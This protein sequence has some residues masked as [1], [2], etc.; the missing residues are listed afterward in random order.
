MEFDP[1]TLAPTYRL[2]LDVPGRSN[3]FEIAAR[4]GLDD[5]LVARARA[6]QPTGGADIDALIQDL[7]VLRQQAE[8][9]RNR[10][11]R[12]QRIASDLLNKRQAALDE[13][14]STKSRQ[15]EEAQQALNRYRR[16]VETRLRRIASR[17][18]R[19]DVKD[20]ATV[21]KLQ[22]QLA[23]V[24]AAEPPR[25]ARTARVRPAP[26]PTKPL[27]IGDTV[28]LVPYGTTGVIEDLKPDQQEARVLIGDMRAWVPLADLRPASRT[29]R[30]E[31]A[32]PRP[33]LIRTAA[34]DV[35]VRPELDIRGVR[36]DEVSHLLDRYLDDALL[37]GLTTVRIIH[38]KGSGALRQA[39][40]DEL[41]RSPAVRTFEL[42][43]QAEGGEGVTVAILDRAR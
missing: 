20:R 42:A 21:K 4:L 37:G 2:I 23:S 32:E 16:E 7:H 11:E 14:E 17:I 34:A 10:A 40:R 9:A 12:D 3:A 22:D 29:E 6:M 36:A 24:Q 43:E 38:G 41:V 15:L 1:E 25:K 13:L 8:T 26:P 28:T 19:L 35:Y 5:A 30:R 27:A 18:D 31:A 39:V 33:T